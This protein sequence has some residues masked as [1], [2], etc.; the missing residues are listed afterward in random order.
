MSYTKRQIIE[1]AHAEIGLGIYAFDSDPEQY[2]LALRRLDSMM[3]EWE[4]AG[5]DLGYPGHENPGDSSLDEDSLLENSKIMAVVKN[6]AVVL[7]PIYGKQ[8]SIHTITS[9]S[10]AY[11]DL[12][13]AAIVAASAQYQYPTIAGAGNR[14]AYKRSGIFMPLP[15]V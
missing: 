9:A 1:D 12:C 4:S 8:A 13:S 15:T 14:N 5:I 2:Q 10:K 6:L 11:S 7:A 3:S